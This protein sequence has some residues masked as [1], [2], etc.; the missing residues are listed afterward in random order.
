[1]SDPNPETAVPAVESVNTGSKAENEIKYDEGP[2]PSY[3]NPH[4]IMP[5]N[6]EVKV[7]SSTGGYFFNVGI[8]KFNDKKKYLGGY[9]HKNNGLIYHHAGT[10]T[11]TEVKKQRET[12]H[13]RTRDTQTYEL[14]S[15]SMA[16]YRE[17]GTQMER[18]DLNIDTK[19]DREIVAKN[20]FSSDK[21]L[22]LKKEKAVEIQ[23]Y[24]RGYMARCLAIS[25]R[26][27]ISDWERK[28]DEDTLAALE[29]LRQTQALQVAR[30]KAPKSNDDF[31]ALYN[32]LD[33]WRKEGV[34]KI[35]ASTAPGE[36]RRMAMSELLVEETQALQNINKLKVAACK[37]ANNNR[38]QQMLE[39]M[40][41]PHK[42][43]MS[44]GNIAAVQTPETI[45]ASKLYEL[46]N[47]LSNNSFKV[48][49]RLNTLLSIKW[50]VN[51]YSTNLTRDI[52][53]LVD[54]E[55]DL[56]SRGRSLTS[57]AGLRKRI[58][59]LFLMFIEEPQFN[60]R[61]SDFIAPLPE[62]PRPGRSFR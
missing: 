41:Q 13:L 58:K 5:E 37:E 27:F 32:E 17:S 44:D 7:A 62:P 43:Q 30:R 53:D 47:Q 14:R 19:R 31:A 42:W 39:L 20:Y 50:T 45:R 46:Y 40:A 38:T 8:E 33:A 55:A 11:P 10:Q 61:A 29:A 2:W 1:M 34:A 35:K 21:L 15:V 51:E 56:L 52:T 48:D 36:E 22:I 60:P 28:Q 12:D 23:R 49:D 25:K 3:A 9:R 54:R 26:E 16:T 57:M 4:Y 59:A 6:I 24:W 18:V